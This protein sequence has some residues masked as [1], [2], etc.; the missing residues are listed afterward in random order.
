MATIQQAILKNQPSA[1]KILDLIPD[2]IKNKQVTEVKSS[3]AVAFTNSTALSAIG[4]L[5]G[6]ENSAVEGSILA[7]VSSIK[8]IS[9]S[10]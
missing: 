4:G 7:P 10:A 1:N 3:N 2:A 8:G 5:S 9:S 6:A